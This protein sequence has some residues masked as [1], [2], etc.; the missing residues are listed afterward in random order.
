MMSTKLGLNGASFEFKPVCKDE[1]QI[2]DTLTSIDGKFQICLGEDNYYRLVTN[3]PNFYMDYETYKD[4]EFINESARIRKM[5]K[6]TTIPIK[7]NWQKIIQDIKENQS[8][9]VKQSEGKLNYELDFEFIA[10]MAEKM[11]LNKAKYESYNWKK[12]IDI[13]LLK[14]SLFRHVIEIMKGDYEDDNRPFG[15]LESA[16]LNCM[17]I[18]YQLKNMQN[19]NTSQ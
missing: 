7:N 5:T 17:M 6:E 12:P 14:Q 4:M 11:S 8:I 13:E 16:S 1:I 10:Q 3:D 19:E 18:N 15:H 9:G 2:I